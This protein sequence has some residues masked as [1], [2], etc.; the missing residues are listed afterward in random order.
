M[1]PSTWFDRGEQDANQDRDD[2]RLFPAVGVHAAAYPRQHELSL[3]P[4]GKAHR[5]EAAK[6]SA[7]IEED[8][9][10]RSLDHGTAQGMLTQGPVARLARP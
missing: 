5:G 2:L 7:G 1:S 6:C 3:C 4:S 9:S 10:D 8:R